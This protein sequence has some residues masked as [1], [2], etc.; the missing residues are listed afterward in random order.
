MSLSLSKIV[1]ALLDW[2]M[3]KLKNERVIKMINDIADMR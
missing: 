3:N 1:V 2:S